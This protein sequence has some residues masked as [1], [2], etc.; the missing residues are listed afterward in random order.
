MSKTMRLIIL[1]AVLVAAAFAIY[2]RGS[3]EP[4]SSTVETMEQGDT[5][6]VFNTPYPVTGPK[7][8]EAQRGK[9]PKP[10]ARK[11]R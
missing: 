5:Q 7:P 11:T 2:F 6:Q 9:S 8:V 3:S 4:P 1:A 10:V